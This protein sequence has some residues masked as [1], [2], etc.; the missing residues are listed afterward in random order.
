VPAALRGALLIA[1]TITLSGGVAT[2]ASD[3]TYLGRPTDQVSPLVHFPLSGFHRVGKPLHEAGRGEVLW[4]GTATGNTSLPERWPVVKALTQFGSFSGI[5]ALD[6]RCQMA[7]VGPFRGQNFCAAPTFD[8]S[9]AGYRS[10]F[11]FFDHKD[12]TNSSGRLFQRMNRQEQTVF[13]RYAAGPGSTERKRI[14]RALR[15]PLLLVGGYLQTVSQIV[16][17]GDFGKPVTGSSGSGSYTG[18]AFDE[19]QSALVSGR[20]PNPGSALVINVNAE[21]NILTALIC[22]GDGLKPAT[23]C[24]RAAIETILKHIE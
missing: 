16:V 20:E 15:L 6:G 8:W 4:L 21:A 14:M 22:R 7:S 18:L 3:I 5:K 17:S 2:A 9:H 24:G 10:A 12:L 11:V 1:V 13:D 23:V 19:V